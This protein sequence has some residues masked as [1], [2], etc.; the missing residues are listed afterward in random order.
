MYFNLIDEKRIENC[1]AHIRQS[2]G[3]AV[4]I[5]KPKRS[6]P[7]NRLYWMLIN[8]IA[9][10]VGFT[11]DEMHERVKVEFLGVEEKM[12]SGVKL[13]VP[14]STAKLSTKQFTD[15]VDKVYILGDKLGIVLP[16]P[17]YWGLE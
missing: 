11:P 13:I 15:L 2:Q 7:Q 1:I 8:V 6:N 10:E 9:N 14:K 16:Q 3:M 4:T 12:V 5:D 17:S